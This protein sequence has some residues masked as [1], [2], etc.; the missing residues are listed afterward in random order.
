VRVELGHRELRLSSPAQTILTLRPHAHAGGSPPYRIVV[1]SY[2]AGGRL[3]EVDNYDLSLISNRPAAFA[4]HRTVYRNAWDNVPAPDLVDRPGIILP[5]VIPPPR[6]PAFRVSVS[7][8]EAI[9]LLY[10]RFPFIMGWTPARITVTLTS[11]NNFRGY[12]TV[13]AN[14]GA[15]ICFPELPKRVFLSAGSTQTIQYTATIVGQL[16]AD[17]IKRGIR[18]EPRTLITDATTAALPRERVKTTLIFKRRATT[19]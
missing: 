5:P 9:I 16:E 13:S 4:T 14:A 19:V 12:V 10:L 6:P 15:W 1:R 2:D 7:P 8:S 18:A 11:V 17:S 3:V